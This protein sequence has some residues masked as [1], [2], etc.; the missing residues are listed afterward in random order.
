MVAKRV[1]AEISKLIPPSGYPQAL[2]PK[3]VPMNITT[4]LSIMVVGQLGNPL[5]IPVGDRVPKLNVETSCKTVVDVD[6]TQQQSYDHCM[7]DEN[8][9]QKQLTSVWSS[10]PGPVRDQCEAEATAGGY[11]SYVDLLT[12]MQMSTDWVDTQ[13]PKVALRGASKKRN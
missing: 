3:E 11:D 6:L 4:L 1:S 9:A 13:S 7:N 2:S 12:C 8:E 10:S 5:A